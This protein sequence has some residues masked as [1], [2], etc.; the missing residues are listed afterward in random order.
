MGKIKTTQIRGILEHRERSLILTHMTTLR[1][2]THANCRATTDLKHY[3]I[4]FPSR[5][6][7][8]SISGAN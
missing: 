3:A 8:A 7:K 2:D 6:T 5:E 4:D 1:R